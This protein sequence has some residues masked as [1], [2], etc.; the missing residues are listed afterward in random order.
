MEKPTPENAMDPEIPDFFIFIFF[1][2]LRV[3]SNLRRYSVHNTRAS[4]VLV[5]RFEVFTLCFRLVM[6]KCLQRVGWQT[7]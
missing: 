4:S 5:F 1:F 3:R 2:N 7:V 6:V